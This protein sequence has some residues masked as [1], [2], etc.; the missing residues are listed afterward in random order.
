MAP[1]LIRGQD[2]SHKVDIWSTGI[3]MMEMAEGNP[4]YMEHPPLRALF[5]ITTK[6]IPGL[7][8]PDAWSGEFRNFVSQSLDLEPSSRPDATQL[9]AHPFL[10]KTADFSELAIAIKRAKQAKELYRRENALD[11]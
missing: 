2:Y 3:M 5:L 7:K 6:G 9:L 10:K 4:P 8:S 1:E 11:L